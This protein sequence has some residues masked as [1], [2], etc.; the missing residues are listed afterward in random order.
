MGAYRVYSYSIAKFCATLLVISSLGGCTSESEV[1][2]GHIIA[3]QDEDEAVRHKAVA[4]LDAIGPPAVDALIVALK[5]ESE[6]AR[7]RAA[8]ALGRLGPNANQSVHALAVALQDKNKAVRMQAAS[9]LQ[10]LS[11]AAA[12]AVEALVGALDDEDEAVRIQVASTLSTLGPAAAPAVEALIIVLHDETESTRLRQLAATALGKIGPAAAPAVDALVAVLGDG[13]LIGV[14]AQSA[15]GAIGQPAVD[16]LIRALLV[17]SRRTKAGAVRALRMIGVPAVDGLIAQLDGDASRHAVDVLVEVGPPAVNAL[18]VALRDRDET[19]RLSAAEALGRIGP[20]VALEE[21]EHPL[22]RRPTPP[23]PA[24]W[25]V[26][27]ASADSVLINYTRRL[28]E[29]EGAVVFVAATVEE[30]ERLE[31]KGVEWALAVVDP[32]WREEKE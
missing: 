26:L 31:A 21:T 15:L 1:I 19:V 17:G 8:W 22:P 24:G 20:V 6:T 13:T 5:D 14:S 11:T 18:L 2:N 23:M 3:L 28:Y 25:S 7:A 29:R 32:A 27:I 4:A 10:V 16:K 12:P 30:M 9:T